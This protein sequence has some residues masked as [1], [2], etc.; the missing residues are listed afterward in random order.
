MR[1]IKSR[2]NDQKKLRYVVFANLREYKFFNYQVAKSF[3]YASD[4]LM[5]TLVHLQKSQRDFVSKVY[6]SISNYK[7]LKKQNVTD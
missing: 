7:T 6:P 1:A 3:M 5:V 2:L 4:G